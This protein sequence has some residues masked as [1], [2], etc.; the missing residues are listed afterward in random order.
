MVDSG[1]HQAHL[2]PGVVDRVG[3][4]W[5][6]LDVIT[7]VLQLGGSGGLGWQGV[8]E[9]GHHHQV[10]PQHQ[11]GTCIHDMDSQWFSVPSHQMKPVTDY[12]AC[13]S[14]NEREINVGL[15]QR[16]AQTKGVWT[17]NQTIHAKR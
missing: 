4:G 10:P 17:H 7:P 9:L 5:L 14:E 13:S 1:Q 11:D 15:K 8:D 6:L 3:C 12:P 16:L 2:H